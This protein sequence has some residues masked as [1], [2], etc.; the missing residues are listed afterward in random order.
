MLSEK[1]SNISVR[2]TKPQNAVY[3]F[4]K[5]ILPAEKPIIIG[6]ITIRA[7]V[8]VSHGINR[9]EFYVDDVLKFNDSK[10]PYRWLWN[11]FAIG[12]H[13]IKVVAY[14]DRGEKASDE[15]EAWIFNC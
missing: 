3:I 10:P 8:Y 13:E 9:V 12:L 6:K 11:E 1:E 7:D 14:D 2:I 5:S 15:I 4:D